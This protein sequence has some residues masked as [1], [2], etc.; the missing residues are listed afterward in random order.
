MDWGLAK[1]LGSGE[2]PSAPREGSAASLAEL[3]SVGMTLE[4]DVMGTPQYMSPEQAEGMVAELDERS[5]IYSLGGQIES[6]LKAQKLPVAFPPTTCAA[7][8]SV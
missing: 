8:C 3:S 7:A 6:V 4:G 5:D 1:M 2:V